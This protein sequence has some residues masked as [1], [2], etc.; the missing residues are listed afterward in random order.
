[1]VAATKS[2]IKIIL[3][4]NVD[5]NSYFIGVCLCCLCTASEIKYECACVRRVPFWR[6]E[7]HRF[8]I[9][10]TMIIVIILLVAC[11][12]CANRFVGLFCQ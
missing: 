10:M 3:N 2:Q 4:E 6:I 8:I 9:M 5:I 11:C 1:M 7:M 12:L